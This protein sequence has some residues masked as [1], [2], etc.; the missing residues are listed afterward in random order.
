[1][2]SIEISCGERRQLVMMNGTIRFAKSKNYQNAFLDI[3]ITKI[4][5]YDNYLQIEIDI[6]KF[7][8][9]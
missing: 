9:I 4:Y 1:M 3:K 5:F 6:V 2:V 8:I 7:D